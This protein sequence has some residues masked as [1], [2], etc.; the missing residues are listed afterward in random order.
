M[1]GELKKELIGILGPLVSAHQE[2]RKTVTDEQVMEFMRPRPLNFG[3]GSTSSSKVVKKAE[4]FLSASSLQTLDDLLRDQSYVVGHQFSQADVKLLSHIKRVP[5]DKMANAKRWYIH[6]ETLSAEGVSPVKLPKEELSLL[7]KQ[8]GALFCPFSQVFLGSINIFCLFQNY[9]SGELL[10]GDL[11]KELVEILTKI[12]VDHQENRKTITDDVV[13]QFMTPRP[14][15]F[16]IQ[17]KK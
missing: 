14:L 16:P 4:P 17:T 5:E 15:N 3:L 9:S 7:W 1:T 6:I 12:C 2:I 10:T 11:K 8:F 13:K